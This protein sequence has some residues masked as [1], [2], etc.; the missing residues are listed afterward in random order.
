M[1]RIILFVVLLLLIKL[2]FGQFYSE[3]DYILV[4]TIVI[5]KPV[6]LKYNNIGEYNKINRILVSEDSIDNKIITKKNM[7][8]KD[9]LNF[10]YKVLSPWLIV[11]LLNY[12]DYSK[13]GD[14]CVYSQL[15]KDLKDYC[16]NDSSYIDI[17]SSNPKELRRNIDML[18]VNCKYFL[19]FLMN[20]RLINRIEPL[21]Y[22]KIENCNNCYLK[23]AVPAQYISNIE[24]PR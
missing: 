15:L 10:G 17:W 3:Y 12:D 13:S 6:I 19:V 24:P 22:Y 14:K 5:S 9:V 23:V 21:E 2:G 16:E 1:K 11:G 18:E 7:Y 4:D 8:Q 20:V